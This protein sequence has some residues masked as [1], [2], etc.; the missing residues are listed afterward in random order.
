[1][2]W[3]HLQATETNEAGLNPMKKPYRHTE[4]LASVLKFEVDVKDVFPQTIT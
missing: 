2:C 1:M 4:N 3:I